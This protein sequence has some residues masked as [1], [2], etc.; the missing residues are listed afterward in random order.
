MF[1]KELEELI[2]ATLQD[3][4]LEDYEKQA[5]IKRAQNEGV[6]IAE[7][8]IYIK[9]KMQKRIQEE[10]VRTKTEKAIAREKKG[11][12]KCPFCGTVIPPL[13]KTCPECGAAISVSNAG[14]SELFAFIDEL[15][16]SMVAVKTADITTFSD[17]KAKAES[18]IR[19]AEMFYEDNKKVQMLVYDLKEEIKKLSKQNTAKKLASGAF[20]YPLQIFLSIFTI[21]TIWFGIGIFPL[22][23]QILLYMH[24][25]NKGFFKKKKL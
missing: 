15:E 20:Y 25:N 23:L 1:S 12:N 14:D 22:I 7:L 4:V 2:E 19:K 11:T 18:L 16:K 13:S 8:E 24:H 9:S 6:D 10:T 21:T 17:E 5:L 3:G